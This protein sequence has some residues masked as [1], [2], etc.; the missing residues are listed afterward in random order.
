MKLTGFA[1]NNCETI[2]HA[3]KIDVAGNVCVMKLTGFAGN[4][5]EK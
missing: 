2:K 4:N 3:I 5:C 1:G